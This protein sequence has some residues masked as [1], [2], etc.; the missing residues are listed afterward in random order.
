MSPAVPATV[1]A[2]L[3]AAR[4][5][6]V[7]RLDAQ[8]LLA[9]HLGRPRSWVLAHDTDALPAAAAPALMADLQRRADGVPLAYLTGEREF[10]GLLLRV[11]PDVL[12]PRPDTETLVDWALDLLAGEMAAVPQPLVVDLGTGSGAIALA[13]KHACPRARMRAVDNSAAALAVARANG[14]R[15]GLV[16]TWLAGD[17]WQALPPP[18]VHLALSNPPYIAAADP[19]LPALRHEPLAALTPGGDGLAAIEALIAGAASHLLPGGWL[20]LEHGYDQGEAVR[21]RL[22]DA[23]FQQ[24]G[25]RRDLAGHERCSGGRRP[26]PGPGRQP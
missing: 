17:W 21:H 24:V 19:H 7:A 1:G 10:H 11:T 20:L 9:H 22:A 4:A 6:G 15:L 14:E 2:A 25:T 16:V 23:G 18:P 13:V 8:W 12:D 5:L 3:A 26:V